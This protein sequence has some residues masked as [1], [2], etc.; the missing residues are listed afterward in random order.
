MPTWQ[1]SPVL[2]VAA[3][4]AAGSTF[5]R[6]RQWSGPRTGRTRRGSEMSV[7]T[8]V[9]M[10]MVSLAL[11]ASAPAVEAQSGTGLHVRQ[12]AGL[13]TMLA[14]VV[15]IGVAGEREALDPLRKLRPAGWGAAA[16]GA[17]LALLPVPDPR[18]MSS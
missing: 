18:T 11:V 6:W 3:A 10:V 16:V 9:V 12:K 1:L 8:T 14:G 13:A 2:V 7:G 5:M 15:L 17:V 4:L